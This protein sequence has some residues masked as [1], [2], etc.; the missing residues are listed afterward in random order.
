MVFI[1]DLADFAYF[2]AVKSS[3]TLQP[4]RVK[5]EFGNSVITFNMDMRGFRLISRIK[6]KTIWPILNAVGI[7]HYF[8]VY[9]LV[10]ARVYSIIALSWHITVSSICQ[11]KLTSKSL[12][13]VGV[14][15]ERIA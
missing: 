2:Y 7:Y 15:S 11:S 9:H 6:E 4:N 1:N 13:K 3:T 5:P 14:V 12:S 8:P 10:S